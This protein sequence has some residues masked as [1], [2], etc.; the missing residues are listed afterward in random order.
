MNVKLLTEFLFEF[1]KLKRRLYRLVWV[2]TCQNATLLEI[3]SRC[4]YIS[5]T[6]YYNHFWRWI[7]Q[8]VHYYN[9]T[10]KLHCKFMFGYLLSIQKVTDCAD[11]IFRVHCTI[12]MTSLKSTSTAFLI[13]CIIF[14]SGNTVLFL[15]SLTQ[16]IS[17][18]I[19]PNYLRRILFNLKIS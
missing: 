18:L 3:T 15:S 17:N 2:Y 10:I 14:V 6:S 5:S 4:S 16:N 19:L 7:L 1:L 11:S 9:H 8:A 12:L 13:H